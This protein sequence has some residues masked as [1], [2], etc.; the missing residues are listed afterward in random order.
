MQYVREKMK[1]TKDKGMAVAA[2]ACL[3]KTASTTSRVEFL[4]F[5]SSY[6]ER[7]TLRFRSSGASTKVEQEKEFLFLVWAVLGVGLRP[8]SSWGLPRFF[9]FFI[10]LL[11]LQKFFGR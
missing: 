2:R 3:P 6:G 11:R 5:M 4:N 10:S 8:F 9:R 1:L 7:R